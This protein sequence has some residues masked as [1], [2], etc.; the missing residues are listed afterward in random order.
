MV[1]WDSVDVDLEPPDSVSC[2]PGQ[3]WEVG[4]KRTSQSVGRSF[5]CDGRIV[6]S[7]IMSSG[8][9]QC[10][11]GIFRFNLSFARRPNPSVLL[12]LFVVAAYAATIPKQRKQLWTF[13]TRDVHIN[14]HVIPPSLATPFSSVLFSTDKLKPWIRPPQIFLCTSKHKLWWLSLQVYEATAFVY[15]STFWLLDV[16]IVHWLILYRQTALS[17][18]LHHSHS[19]VW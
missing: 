4:R 8:A 2:R 17:F 13:C 1:C 7:R 11:T 15:A 16:Q 18:K 5:F 9:S 3:L 12:W 19:L 10:G 6:C 14:P